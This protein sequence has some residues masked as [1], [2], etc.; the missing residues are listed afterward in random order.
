MPMVLIP[1]LMQSW[2]REGLRPP[3]PTEEDFATALVLILTLLAVCHVRGLTSLCKGLQYSNAALD[4][5][6]D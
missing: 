5:F 2:V 1:G 6:R 3:T 4:L